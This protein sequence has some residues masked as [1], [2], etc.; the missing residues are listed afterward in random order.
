M[1]AVKIN[2]GSILENS[3]LQRSINNI[4]KFLLDKVNQKIQ[5]IS[6]SNST[7]FIS[8]NICPDNDGII[9]E[10]TYKKVIKINPED[11]QDKQKL[12]KYINEIRYFCEQVSKI[13]E[14]QYLP[15]NFRIKDD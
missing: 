15:I 5:I 13:D 1:L 4:K 8:G 3:I 10:L 2:F 12:D 6:D 7:E 14:L 11:L 9:T